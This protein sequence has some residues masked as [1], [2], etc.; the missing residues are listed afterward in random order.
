MEAGR[1]FRLLPAPPPF[2]MDSFGSESRVFC[3]RDP[4]TAWRHDGKMDGLDWVNSIE[5]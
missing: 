2:L 3:T 4:R 5:W 1:A